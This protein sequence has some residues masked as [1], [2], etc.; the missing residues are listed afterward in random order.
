MTKRLFLGALALCLISA[1]PAQAQSNRHF[2]ECIA[3]N[4][5]FGPCLEYMMARSTYS[6]TAARKQVRRLKLAA[7]KD[8][9]YLAFAGRKD[10]TITGIRGCG[11]AWRSSLE[12]AQKAAMARCRQKEVEFGTAGG[13]KVCRLMN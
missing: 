9:V 13:K 6:C 2:D 4:E 8:G 12:E 11:I 3:R 5:T 10:S 7:A 1:A